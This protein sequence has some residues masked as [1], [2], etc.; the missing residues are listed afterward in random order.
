MPDIP[1]SIVNFLTRSTLAV[2]SAAVQHHAAIASVQLA[3]HR[4][5]THP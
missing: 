1:Y 2:A 5:E 3:L 4:Q